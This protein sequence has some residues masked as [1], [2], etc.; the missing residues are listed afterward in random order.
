MPLPKSAQQL[1]ARRKVVL[2]ANGIS[3]LGKFHRDTVLRALA[4]GD[5]EADSWLDGRGRLTPLFLP[6]VAIQLARLLPSHDP[7]PTILS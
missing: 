2:T 4:R 5:I 3:E 7:Q 6:E 1:T